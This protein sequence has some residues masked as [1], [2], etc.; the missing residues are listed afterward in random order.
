MEPRRRRQEVAPGEAK[1]SL[2]LG[3]AGGR[4]SKKRHGPRG[5]PGRGCRL[6]EARAHFWTKPQIPQRPKNGD[7]AASEA[8][9]CRSFGTQQRSCGGELRLLWKR[10]RQPR[11]RS[12]PAASAKLN[13]KPLPSISSVT[14]Y[15]GEPCRGVG[16]R[17]AASPYSLPSSLFPLPRLFSAP[18]A[19]RCGHRPA[20][21]RAG[22]GEWR[23]QRSGG[24][25]R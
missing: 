22:N 15:S 1:R 8:M 2:E 25:S 16:L 4:A 12:S 20:G 6:S 14:V 13:T 24:A 5:A 3:A 18:P 7:A 9:F 19:P 10:V 21:R 23:R 11:I 17:S